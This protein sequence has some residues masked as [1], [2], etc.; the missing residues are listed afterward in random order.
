[1]LQ[2]LERWKTWVNQNNEIP[3]EAKPY[4]LPT[5]TIKGIKICGENKLFYIC[6]SVIIFILA[7]SLSE[8]IR[9]LLSHEKVKF[10]LTE[11]F[12]QDPLENFFGQ[13]R[14]RGQRN[15]NPSVSQFLENTQALMVQKSLPVGGSSSI[16][17]R[18]EMSDLIRTIT[19]STITKTC[20]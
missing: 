20:M 10:V 5:Q 15:D 18:K 16:R 19:K 14:A 8:M 2:Y 1:M 7:H 9:F 12:N 17:K 13:Q 3:K 6:K 4:Q 11:R